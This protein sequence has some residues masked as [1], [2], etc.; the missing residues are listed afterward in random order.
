[1]KYLVIIEGEKLSVFDCEEDAFYYIKEIANE[2]KERGVEKVDE[3]LNDMRT[4]Y[5]STKYNPYPDIII[6][7]PEE[8]VNIVYYPHE[9]QPVI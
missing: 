5:N 1:M 9:L 4:K 2:M 3:W 6:E 7:L 8:D